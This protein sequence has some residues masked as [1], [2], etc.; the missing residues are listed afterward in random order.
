MLS[1]FW[2][3]FY[4]LTDISYSIIFILIEGLNFRHTLYPAYKSNRPPTPDT[5]VQGLQY[6]K[7]SL[8]S[9]SITVIEVIA[10]YHSFVWL[11]APL[12]S[13]DWLLSTQRQVPG[14]EADDVIGTLTVRSVD[15][16]YKVIFAN[17]M[18][19]AC[20]LKLTCFTM[21]FLFPGCN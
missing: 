17:Y 6:L 2:C 16:G 10:L 13:S 7:A 8:K 12:V 14:V 21:I 3:L 20:I 11:V 19:K 4:F 18:S 9:M 15:N 5:I 1:I